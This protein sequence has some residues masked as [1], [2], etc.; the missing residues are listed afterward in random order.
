MP[1]CDMVGRRFRDLTSLVDDSDI[2]HVRVSRLIRLR[3]EQLYLLPLHLWIFTKPSF[4][5]TKMLIL[6]LVFDEA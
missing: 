2:G 3:P 6:A 5:Y 4:R 1:K